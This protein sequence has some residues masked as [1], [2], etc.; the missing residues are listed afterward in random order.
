MNLIKR[1]HSVVHFLM[2]KDVCT[3]PL[4]VELV[5]EEDLIKEMSKITDIRTIRGL[6]PG[7]FIHFMGQ[8]FLSLH[9]ISMKVC[10]TRRSN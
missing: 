5:L 7:T 9:F 4:S 2:L 6:L 8:A 1:L 10:V 3:D